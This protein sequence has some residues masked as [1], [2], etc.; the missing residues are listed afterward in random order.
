MRRSIIYNPNA[1]IQVM[2]KLI[3]VHFIFEIL[4]IYCNFDAPPFPH[5]LR[6]RQIETNTSL[7]HGDINIYNKTFF[8]WYFQK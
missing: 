4:H 8:N 2:Q 5:D 1:P 6:Q 7:V 3:S